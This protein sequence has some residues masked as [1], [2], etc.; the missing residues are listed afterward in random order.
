MSEIIELS[1][2][3]PAGVWEDIV[4][5]FLEM[6]CDLSSGEQ[7]MLIQEL[8][9]QT[10]R[11]E[12]IESY[13]SFSIEGKLITVCKEPAAVYEYWLYDVRNSQIRKWKTEDRPDAA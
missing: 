6:S 8:R 11:A 13:P 2:F 4:N 1:H 10:L 3:Y 7:T 12:N 5:D 9:R